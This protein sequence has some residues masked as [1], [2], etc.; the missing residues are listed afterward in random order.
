MVS[1]AEGKEYN[2][3]EKQIGDFPFFICNLNES[4]IFHLSLGVNM[5]KKRKII[6][7]TIVLIIVFGLL[8]V[9]N[10]VL[11]R[12][13]VVRNNNV[14]M[15]DSDWN[16][17][18]AKAV[19]KS[20]IVANIDKKQ[21]KSNINGIYMDDTMSLMFPLK[22]IKETFDCAVGKYSDSIL[23]EKGNVSL[24][25]Y[26]KSNEYEYN[27]EVKHMDNALV[28]NGDTYYI[29]ADVICSSLA[30][31]YSFDL[32]T[33]QANISSLN[34]E[35]RTIPYAYN[36]ENVGRISAVRN[37][38]NL[39]TC[40][41]FAALT[42][43]ESTLMPEEFL[44][45]SVDHMTLN[46]SFSLSQDDGGD[47]TMSMAYLLAWQGPVLEKDDPYGDG[48][49]NPNLKAVRHVQEI[50][51]IESKDFETIKKM[52]FK[53]GGVQ[54]SFYASVLTD[55]T[56]SSRYYN[57]KTYSYCYIGSD[58]PNHD[59]VIIGWDDNYPKENFNMKLEGN[60]AFICR[61]SWGS[62]FGN[63]G[64]F[65]I[66]YYD[67]N[68]GVHNTVYTKVEK[69]NNYD[70]IYQT[71]LCGYVGQ[72]GYL[73]E[74]A[75]FAN[76]YTAKANE[77]IKAVGFYATGIDTEYSIYL[78]E[79][80]QDNTSLS[81]RSDPIMTGKI[82]HTGY[83]TIPLDSPIEVSKDQ[84]YAIIIRITTPN[85]ERPIAV[86]FVNDSQTKDVDLSD[87]E[88]Y[89]SYKGITWNRTEENNN[90]NVCLK[91]YTDNANTVK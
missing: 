85:S 79:D 51:I 43:L 35:S 61:N 84:K 62:T 13:T 10:T 47:Y 4:V 91:V 45:F 14:L 5:K 59:I 15:A 22:T 69:S 28:V 23:I 8:I 36:Y 6:A 2:R 87:G 42:A 48:V 11:A 73:D 30:Y 29:S 83:Y 7:A 64:D 20:I 38:G 32:K 63:N 56:G 66:S 54:S 26:I 78:C 65:Y 3:K 16:P 37:Q 71:D 53:Y 72:L 70:N 75:Y 21:L 41:A 46:N 18:I 40:W 82:T 25:L 33:N 77:I 81:K 57:D 58:K 88:G 52:I 34:D 1:E 19:N 39:G 31:Q 49:T 17:T 76:A 12:E 24:K 80:F 68:I 9:Y 86:E 27:G 55:R 44:K 50:Q 90:C 60:G 67:S 89:V 74:S